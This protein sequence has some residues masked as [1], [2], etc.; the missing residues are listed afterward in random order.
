MG[1]RR[2]SDGQ[3]SLPGWWLDG[4]PGPPPKALDRFCEY[5]R[6]AADLERR[7]V[8]AGRCDPGM[9]GLHLY[10]MGIDEAALDRGWAEAREVALGLSGEDARLLEEGYLLA[11]DWHDVAAELGMGYDQVKKRAYRAL[12]WLDSRHTGTGADR[13]N[14]PAG[15]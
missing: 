4:R 1:R 10:V 6:R 8:A 11:R 5:R 13:E 3:G 14:G 2:V 15:T 12:A 7:K 9:R